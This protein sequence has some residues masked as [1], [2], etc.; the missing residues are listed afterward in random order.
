[1]MFPLSEP[2]RKEAWYSTMGEQVVRHVSRCSQVGL[3]HVAKFSIDV[4]GNQTG[5][6]V[7][8]F[9][10]FALSVSGVDWLRLFG[11]LFCFFFAAAS[12]LDCR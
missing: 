11:F 6:F 8:I 9:D 10:L 7:V 12:L 2:T 3:I 5:S 1:M 4:A